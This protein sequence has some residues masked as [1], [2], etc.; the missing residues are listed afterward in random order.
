M[1]TQN[2]TVS[3]IIPTYNRA[4][5]LER[6]IKSV[7]NQTYE[8]LELLVVDDGSSDNTESL[9]ARFCDQRIKYIKHADNIGAP[10]TR[11]TGIKRSKGKYIA[12]LDSDDEWLPRKL[13]KQINIFS[14]TEF[15]DIGL[16]YTGAHLFSKPEDDP[17]NT[18]IPSHQGDI[19]MTLLK[20]GNVICGGGSAA[21]IKRECFDQVG[22]FNEDL[23]SGQDMEMWLRIC[24]HYSVDFVKKIMVHVYF[25]A[26]RRISHR[27]LAKRNFFNYLDENYYKKYLNPIQRRKSKAR[28]QGVIGQHYVL[29]NSPY[30]GRKKLLRSILNY[31]FS[32]KNWVRFGLSLFGSPIYK[33][34]HPKLASLKHRLVRYLKN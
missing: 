31:P 24:E 9:V 30:R 19:F 27:V 11:N 3:V 18:Q 4:E 8:E 17:I 28:N 10:A 32:F 16:V 33:K 26:T 23:L 20:K 34:I 29:K 7:L 2:P 25:H 1:M 14:E 5:L 13:E 15:S 22:L 12:F 6:A 21:M